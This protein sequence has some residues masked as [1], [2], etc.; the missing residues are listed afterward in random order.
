MKLSKQEDNSFNLEGLSFTQLKTI[1]DACKTYAKQ[2]SKASGDIASEI[3]DMMDN[4]TV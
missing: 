3:E 1:K 4:I 2:G